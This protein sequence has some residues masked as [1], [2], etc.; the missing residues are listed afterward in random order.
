MCRWSPAHVRNKRKLLQGL[1][2]HSSGKNLQ[3]GAELQSPRWRLGFRSAGLRKEAWASDRNGS[4]WSAEGCG[5]W[6]WKSRLPEWHLPSWAQKRDPAAT[7]CDQSGQDLLTIKSGGSQCWGFFY[8]YYFCFSFNGQLCG[9][10]RDQPAHFS[11]WIMCQK[12]NHWALL[13][14]DP[15]YHV[16]EIARAY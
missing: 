6:V 2:G 15:W 9:I 16:T 3:T 7:G 5:R 1:T 4:L 12:E 13:P 10:K 8:Y 11:P 14:C